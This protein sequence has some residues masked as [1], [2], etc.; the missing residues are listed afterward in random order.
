MLTV[1]KIGDNDNLYLSLVYTN[2]DQKMV[3]SPENIEPIK[4]SNTGKYS[5]GT[6]NGCHSLDWD[7][8]SFIFEVSKYGD[9]HG[10]SISV[11]INNTSEL[12][13]SF[14]NAIDQWN[15]YIQ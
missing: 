14:K 7:D 5:S 15:K 4:F 9:G 10:G 8:N 6:S 3:F 12:M 2:N 13:K 11:K 1:E